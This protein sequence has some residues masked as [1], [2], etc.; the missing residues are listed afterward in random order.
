MATQRISLEALQKI[1]QHIKRAIVLSESENHPK[2]WSKTVEEPPKPESLD[3]LGDLF[4]FGSIPE[5][6]LQ[7]P[8]EQGQWFISASNP[9]TVLMKLPGLGLK[10]DWRLVIYLYRMGNDGTSIMWAVP[11]ALSRTADLQNALSTCGGRDNPPQPE[12]A[13]TDV[14]DAIAGDGS[15]MSFVIAS[16]VRREFSELGRLGKSAQWTHH[17]LID[18]LP[19]QVPWQWRSEAPQDL[20]PKVQV[21]PDGK[22]A[23]EF[24]TCRVIAPI[25]VFQH[26]DHYGA[27]TYRAKSLDRSVAIARQA[28]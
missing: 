12:G 14:M 2:P 6:T 18:G 15:P 19:P 11:T 24:F 4:H 7:I 28:T 25:A 17:R 16:L 26:V 21:F 22:V 10:P 5:E 8:N 3:G 1:R 20:S 23:I 9:G 13:L 27:E